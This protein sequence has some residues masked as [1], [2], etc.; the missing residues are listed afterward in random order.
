MGLFG[1]EK[2]THGLLDC[3]H[4]DASAVEQLKEDIANATVEKL[5]NKLYLRVGRG[6]V[7][8]ALWLI[9]LGAVSVFAWLNSK[10]LLP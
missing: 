2:D 5:E 10:G 6:V 9:G 4:L 3:P 8:K 1:K 7:H